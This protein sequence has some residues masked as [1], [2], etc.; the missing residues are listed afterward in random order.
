MD[1]N[2]QALFE[3]LL[4]KVYGEIPNEAK[5]LLKTSRFTPPSIDE[6]EQFLRDRNVL[7]PKENA[8]KFHSFYESK[9]WMVG[10]NKMKNW[11]SAINTWDFP[12]KGL[13]I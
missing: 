2:T 7:S 11:K 3:M 1:K 10:K 6:V 5:V 4:N 8:I 9:G 13:V 12:K